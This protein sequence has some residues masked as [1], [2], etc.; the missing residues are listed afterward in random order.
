M[1]GPLPKPKE[2]RQRRNKPAALVKFPTAVKAPEI[3]SGLLKATVELWDKFWGSELAQAVEV[4]TD[5]AVVQRLFT[6]YDER[7]RAFRAY[8]D[9]RMVIGSQGQAVLNPMARLM[10]QLDVEIRQLEDRLGMNPVARLRL[11]ITFASAQKSLR[12]LNRN[13]EIDEEED[14]R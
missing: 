10:S 12:D 7:E 4:S 14:P 3:P 8:R 5:T 1:S 9:E 11:G 2:R 6:L 13:L